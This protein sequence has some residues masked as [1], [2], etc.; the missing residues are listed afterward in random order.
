LEK[1]VQP[2]GWHFYIV[3][4]R[5]IDHVST[6]RWPSQLSLPACSIVSIC[7]PLSRHLD[8][9]ELVSLLSSS[10]SRAVPDAASHLRVI[11]VG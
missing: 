6:R 11:H 1:R 5:E 4:A 9:D 3:V 8:L 10:C 7:V 2:E